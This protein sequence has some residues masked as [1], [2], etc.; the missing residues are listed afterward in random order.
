MNETEREELKSRLENFGDTPNWSVAIQLVLNIIMIIG[1]AAFILTA[2]GCKS[3]E[4]EVIYETKE[5]QVVVQVPPPPIELP[6][7]PTWETETADESEYLE[8]LRC[9]GRDLLNAWAYIADLE[10]RIESHNEAIAGPVPE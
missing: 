8:Y 5:V 10:W 1:M 9:V 6:D 2:G 3:C 7:K 4:P